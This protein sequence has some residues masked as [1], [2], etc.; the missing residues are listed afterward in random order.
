MSLF[1]FN[2]M[3]LFNIHVFSF[4]SLVWHPVNCTPTV[5]ESCRWS[6]EV[7]DFDYIYQ[8][9][10]R[11]PGVRRKQTLCF[12]VDVLNLKL[13]SLSVSSDSHCINLDDYGI[14]S[15][16]IIYF[17]TAIGNLLK[18]MRIQSSCHEYW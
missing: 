12:R 18:F 11:I 14:D 2:P 10:D 13:P 1:L 15:N 3:L 5:D 6:L 7:S 9:G 4:R 8:S 16:H 17:I